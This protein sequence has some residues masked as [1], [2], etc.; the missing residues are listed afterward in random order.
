VHNPDL[1]MIDSP[2]ARA[3]S[4]RGG[5]RT[6]LMLPLRKDGRLLGAISCNRQ[7]VRPFADKEIA[8]LESF[9]AQAVIAMDNARLLDEIRQR[10]AELRVTFD[11]MGDGVAMFDGELQLA[12]WNLNFQR[13]LDLPD[14]FLAARPSYQ[15]YGRYL[16]ERGEYG[17]VDVEA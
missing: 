11:N 12:A 3:V 2:T 5:V 10:Q 6:N 16:A 13:I 4:G 8:L 7:E 1:T 9:A 15:D 14:A 17:A